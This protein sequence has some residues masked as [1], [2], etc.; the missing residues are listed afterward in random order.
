MPESRND[1]PHEYHPRDEINNYM[2][3]SPSND[4][5]GDVDYSP[6][7]RESSRSPYNSDVAPGPFVDE[8][9]EVSIKNIFEFNFIV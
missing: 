7:E 5:Y 2:P 3:E 8:E 4:A 6:E 9:G 1:S